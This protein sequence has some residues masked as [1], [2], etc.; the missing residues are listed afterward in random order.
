MSVNPAAMWRAR[1]GLP[2]VENQSA[3]SSDICYFHEPKRPSL[4][5]P[6]PTKIITGL[7]QRCGIIAYAEQSR[8]FSGGR[9]G[10]PF[11]GG[12]GG[13]SSSSRGGGGGRPWQQRD[14]NDDRGRGDRRGGGRGGRGGSRG[15]YP[16]VPRD[17]DEWSGNASSKGAQDSDDFFVADDEYTPNFQS[18]DSSGRG[19]SRGWEGTN[20]RG[21]GRRFRGSGGRGGAG[22]WRGGGN[23]TRGR[24]DRNNE[25]SERGGGWAGNTDRGEWVTGERNTFEGDSGDEW[26]GGDGNGESRWKGRGSTGAGQYRRDQ[27]SV[28]PSLKDRLIGDVVYGVS[29]VL[30]ALQAGRRKVHALYVQES[31]DAS[32]RKDK[33]ALLAASTLAKDLGA[34]VYSTSKHEMNMVS[35]NK[36][37]QGLVLD[38]SEL[39]FETME[40]MPRV[41][42][43]WEE[44]SGVAPPVWLCLDEVMDPVRCRVKKESAPLMPCTQPSFPSR[45]FLL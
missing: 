9:R 8:T 6:Y 25:R 22:E 16:P 19:R 4:T 36:P 41:E 44:G 26:V 42:D 7:L 15:K 32:K 45:L 29:P 21:G 28:A 30:A 2:Q 39:D 1:G 11:G 27:G 40:T 13:G 37:H 3:C 17:D 10:S 31:A 43:V 12:R 5:F 20:D 35:D 18:S 38:A 14:A 33:S 34:T 23:G 24:N